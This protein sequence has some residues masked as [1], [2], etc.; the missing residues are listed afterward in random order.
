LRNEHC[1]VPPELV[2]AQL[3]ANSWQRESQEIAGD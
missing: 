3:A 1:E 2:Q